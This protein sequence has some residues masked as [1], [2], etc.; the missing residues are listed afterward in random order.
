M[1]YLTTY[2]WAILIMAVVTAILYLY[3]TTPSTVVPTSCV[4]ISGVY[5]NAMV[6]GTNTITHAT[7]VALF[8]T[9][10]QP[11]PL[12]SPSIYAQLNGANTT[13]ASCSPNYVIQAGSMVCVLNLPTK[14]S[15]GQFLAG[16]LYLEATYCGINT[17]YSRS[18]L[19]SGAPKETYSGS[20]T[21]HVEPL[22]N[23]NTTITLTAQNSTQLANNA[24]DPLIATV[25]LLG[26][27]LS[28]ATVNFTA[29]VPG[30]SISPNY[31]TT[32]STGKALSYIWGT[33]AGNVL[34]TATYAGVSANTTIHFAPAF[35]VKFNINFPYCSSAGQIITIDGVS[36]TCSQL[37]SSTF[38]WSS[39]SVHSCNL[40]NPLT[41]NSLVRGQCSMTSGT[42]GSCTAS[43]NTT[44]NINC[45]SQY[46]LTMSASPSSA[47]SV[48]PTSNWY[49]Q[50]SVVGIN[51]VTNSGFMFNGWTGTGT[52]SYTGASSS[53][54]VTMNSP[55]SETSSYVTNVVFTE[56]G[57]PGGTSWSVTLNGNTLSSTGSSII[58]G[59]LVPGSYP[60][61]TNGISCGTGCQYTPS[62]SSGSVSTASG[63]ASKPLS[64]ATQYYLTMSA[65]TNGAVSPSS[66]WQN[67][68]NVVTIT[69]NPNSN[70][71]FSTWAGSGT[72][73]YSGTT[74]PSTVTMSGPISET[75]SFVFQT[76]YN[77][78]CGSYSGDLVYS[79]STTLTCNT[80]A[81]NSITINSGV[82]VNENGFYL[83]ANNTF[84][85]AGTITDS[86]SG[87]SGGA[88]GQAGTYYNTPPGAGSGGSGSAGIIRTSKYLSTTLT[89]GSGGSGTGGTGYGGAGG[90]CDS[91]Y[92]DN[93]PGA[94][95]ASGGNGG[96]IVEIYAG[97]FINTGVINVAGQSGANGNNGNNGYTTTGGCGCGLCTFG[98]YCYASAGTSGTG[99]GKGGNGGTIFIGYSN[100]LTIGTTNT[101]AGAGGSGSSGGS[102][103]C[104]PSGSSG[105]AGTAGSPGSL[106]TR[107]WSH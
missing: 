75:G 64:Y 99:G 67:S 43:S 78:Q 88:G 76:I 57:L 104:L 42:P 60:W 11:Y 12:A 89:G 84:T 28:G 40:N 52:V 49:N 92:G 106:I 38:S 32:N 20:F 44:I 51:Q 18:N 6:I 58:F 63:S 23:T 36:Y 15:L 7:T 31:T 47:G 8:L 101:L 13:Q 39:G 81:S 100:T 21:S 14:T 33:T 1:E 29:N 79:S 10:S 107:S 102:G 35:N 34:V 80:V 73:S 96:G 65:G 68:G 94:P 27:P 74:N 46:F 3:S 95:G 72:G 97:N 56:S 91:I 55:V 50:S 93:E 17:N 61:S 71:V 37:S 25:K 54:S 22:I 2:G 90:A 86:K 69:G 62:S 85:N 24:K 105:P 103:L 5:C 48:S 70:Y 77:S 82:T 41:V 66:G 16:K 53:A 19:C 87:G 45:T 83:E 26:Y 98:S 9:N 59:N 30:Y 4:F